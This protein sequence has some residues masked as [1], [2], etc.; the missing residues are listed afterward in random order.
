MKLF[1]RPITLK[2]KQK[3]NKPIKH[4]KHQKQYDFSKKKIK[5]VLQ[6][7]VSKLLLRI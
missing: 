7:L 6:N 2:K 5:N 1:T 3:I 4:M